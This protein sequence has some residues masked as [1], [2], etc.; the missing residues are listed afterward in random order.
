MFD[1]SIATATSL[2]SERIETTHESTEPISL[3]GE[4]E[5]RYQ[6][7]LAW[8]DFNSA[9]RERT[10]RVLAMFEEREARDEL[11]LGGIRDSFSDH[12]FPGTSTIQTRLRYLFF[13]PWMYQFL[14]EKRTT[15]QD[16]AL[17][18]RKMELNLTKP[19]LEA[20]GPEAGV[21]GRIAKE[22]LK[23]LP[24]SVYWAALRQY[25]ICRYSGGREDFHRAFESLWRRRQRGREDGQGGAE[26]LENS[27]HPKLPSPPGEFPEEPTFLLTLEEAHFFRH[28][29]EATWADSLL[30][31]LAWHSKPTNIEFPWEH[32]DY[33]RF[34]D[35][36][37]ELLDNARLF[38]GN[39]ARCLDP[40]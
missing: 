38:F 15:A 10:Q 2:T 21:F 13:V 31:Y 7:T 22:K 14:A 19:L 8:L 6:S 3:Y 32:P 34:S 29:L 40:L 4:L 18:A 23:R 17:R 39:H 12:L 28:C 26:R 16:V 1:K 37:R 33:A 30:M 35:R 20:H 9:E 5:H 36:H 25:G 11:G 24:S 27:W